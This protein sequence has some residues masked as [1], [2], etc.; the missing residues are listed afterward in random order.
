MAEEQ[1]YYLGI[2]ATGRT[3]ALLAGPDGEILGEGT[4]TSAVY[5]VMGQERSSQALWTAIIGA[6]SSAGINTRDLLQANLTLPEVSAICV[7]MS[8]V[9]RPKDESQVRRILDRFNLTKNII[10][11][12]DAHIVLEAGCNLE[13]YSDPAYGVAVLAGE[14]GLAFAK[15]RDGRT[16]RA[17]GWGYLLGEEGSAYWLGLQAVKALLRAADGR[18]EATALAAMVEH[19]WKIPAN[20]PDT[21]AQRVYSLLAGLGTGGNKAQLE[22]SQE[23]YKRTLAGLAPLVER[24]A[25]NGDEVASAIVDE[26]AAYLAEAANAALDR[27]GLGETGATTAPAP[28]KNPTFQ[29]GG[30]AFNLGKGQPAQAKIP[31]AI[32]GS[33][34]LSNHG[35][36]RDRLHAALPQ[37]DDP[38]AVLNPAE[39]AVRLALRSQG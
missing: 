27:T 29:I 37:C 6:F 11:T 9:E 39:G 13:N 14:N 2:E 21:L 30:M 31:L 26:A 3:V 19:E 34:L 35:Q 25:A 17:G 20:R 24:A 28:A 16:A 36:L 38:I 4:A 12:S 32:Y 22:E 7:G 23:T 1:P 10:V 15:G 5:S 18:G 33:V 8:G